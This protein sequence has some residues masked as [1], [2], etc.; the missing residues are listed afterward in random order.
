LP[1]KLTQKN[2]NQIDKPNSFSFEKNYPYTSRWL[3]GYGWI[4]IGDDG[5]SGCFIKVLD[6]GGMIWVTKKKYKDIDAAFQALEKALA[7]IMKKE[8]GE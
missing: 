6:E 7:A 8:F 4:E 5:Y 2:K 3:K 1:K